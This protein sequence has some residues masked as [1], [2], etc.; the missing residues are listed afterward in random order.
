[1]LL[2]IFNF[3]TTGPG[4]NATLAIAPLAVAG[5]LG[6]LGLLKGM[7]VDKAK[8]DRQR[9]LAAETA[10][11]SPWTQMQPGD[12]QE[13]DP[14]GSTMQGGMSGWAFGQGMENH[15]SAKKFQDAM[16]TKLLDGS[17]QVAVPLEGMGGAQTSFSP[18]MS[19]K[20]RMG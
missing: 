15:D 19:I 8:E 2:E 13:A 20:P 4:G 1:M 5:I 12:V 14:F 16:S 10:R 9:K 11:Y 6:G 7:T 17:G 3:L 18:Y